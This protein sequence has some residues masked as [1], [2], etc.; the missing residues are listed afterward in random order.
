MP[1]VLFNS[2][3][4]AHKSNHFLVGVAR[5]LYLLMTAQPV[6]NNMVICSAREVKTAVYTGS[7]QSL[8]MLVKKRH[9]LTPAQTHIHSVYEVCIL[10]FLSGLP[11]AVD[12]DPFNQSATQLPACVHNYHI[13]QLLCF[14]TIQQYPSAVLL[15]LLIQ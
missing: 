3:I 5:Q 2:A 9:F 4:L 6:H 1:I 12:N 13:P 14:C 15:R 8:M 10:V 7:L 11:H